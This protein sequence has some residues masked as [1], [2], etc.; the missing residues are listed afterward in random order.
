MK[1]TSAADI[2]SLILQLQEIKAQHSLYEQAEI[3]IF[4]NDS[5]Q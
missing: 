1:I 3:A 2:A 5:V 4:F